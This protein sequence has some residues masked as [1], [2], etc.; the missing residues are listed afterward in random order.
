MNSAVSEDKWLVDQKFYHGF[1]PREDLPYVLKRKGDYIFRVT[2]RKVGKE[3]KRDIVL[4]V[5]WPTTPAPLLSAKDIKNF[6]IERNANSVWLE[7]TV[8]LASLESLHNHYKNTDIVAQNKEK[9]KIIRPICLFSWEFKH[10]QIV[11]VKKVGQGAYGEVFHGKVKR[12]AKTFDAAIK[13]M[14]SDLEAADEKMKEVMAEARLM[15]SLNHPNIVRCRG[16]AVLEQPVYIVIDFITGGGLDSFLKK[17]GKTLSMD[18]KNKMAIS[19][20]WGI[21]YMHSNDIIHRDIAARNCLYDKKNLVKLSDFGL[22][23]KGSVYKMKKAMKMP[24][25][26]LAPESLTT[27]TFSRASDTYTYGVLLYEIY[28]CQEP[29]FGVNAAEARRLV[30]SGAFPNFSKHSPPELT[31]IVRKCIYQLDPL[32][33]ASM[34]EV[35]KKLEAWLEVELVLDEDQKPEIEHPESNRNNVNSKSPAIEHPAPAGQMAPLP[36]PIPPPTSA[37]PPPIKREEEAVKKSMKRKEAKR[38]SSIET[39]NSKSKEVKPDG[40]LPVEPMSVANKMMSSAKRGSDEL[41]LTPPDEETKPSSK[42]TE[43]DDQK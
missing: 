43:S 21:E 16:I 1:L 6:L 8:R 12:G 18:E 4:S 22:S 25:K 17:N 23:R 37:P 28:T 14:R 19:A 41:L 10:S 27:F 35:V 32:K 2:E 34:K 30:L 42:E 11:L 3:T 29:Y 20:A 24:T 26:W 15:R 9:F 13:A 5:A 31:D 7:S 39:S 33:R 40:P 38:D 36:Q